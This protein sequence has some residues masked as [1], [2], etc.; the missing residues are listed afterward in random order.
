MSLNTSARASPAVTKHAGN[1]WDQRTDPGSVAPETAW[2]YGQRISVG[3]QPI[4]ADEVRLHWSSGTLLLRKAGTITTVYTL[5]EL[6]P[7]TYHAIKH[8]LPDDYRREP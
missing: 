8:T 4:C 5:D 7:E 2:Q 3:S 6:T 1:R